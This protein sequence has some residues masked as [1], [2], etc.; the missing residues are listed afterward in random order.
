MAPI[1]RIFSDS[2]PPPQ[3]APSSKK[4]AAEPKRLPP[5]PPLE[6]PAVTD[7]S[8]FNEKDATIREVFEWYIAN[9]PSQSKCV[10]S[11]HQ[12]RRLYG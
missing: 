6:S 10:K 9:N 12:R 7:Y 1:L 11:E 4:P 3:A 2:A 8:K 5:S